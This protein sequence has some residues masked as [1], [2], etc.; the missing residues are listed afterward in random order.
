MSELA[1]NGVPVTTASDA[2][3]IEE[4]ARGRARIGRRGGRRIGRLLFSAEELA[5]GAL[6]VF[7]DLVEGLFKLHARDGINL[8]D[9]VLCV[10]NG[11]CQIFA[12]R[13]EESMPLG[14]FFVLF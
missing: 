4:L 1:I 14:S 11:L 6:K 10:L 7:V 13:F 12:L 9:G 8:F 5:E 3:L 2:E